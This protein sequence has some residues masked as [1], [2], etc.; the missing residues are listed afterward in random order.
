MKPVYKGLDLSKK[1]K[2]P[3]REHPFWADKPVISTKDASHITEVKQMNAPTLEELRPNPYDLPEGY[4]WF[5]IDIRLIKSDNVNAKSD[6]DIKFDVNIEM[7]YKFLYE[8]YVTYNVGGLQFQLEY[9]IDTIL[10]ILSHTEYNPELHLGIRQISSQKIIGFITGTPSIIKLYGNTCKL[11]EINLLCVDPSYRGK[12]LAPILIKEVTRRIEIKSNDKSHNLLYSGAI[13][14]AGIILPNITCSATWHHRPLNPKKLIDINFMPKQK[15]ALKSVIKIHTID[16]KIKSKLG[17]LR[18]VSIVDAPTCCALLN[19]FLSAYHISVE[20]SE[21]EFIQRF[22]PATSVVK[23][24]V[25]ENKGVIT[26]FISFYGLPSKIHGHKHHQV[27]N[28]AY[29]YYMATDRKNPKLEERLKD[30]M[31]IALCL[32]QEMKFD[33]FNCLNIMENESFMKDLK[34]GVGDGTLQYHLYNWQCPST[35]PAGIGFFM[36]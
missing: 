33:V 13:Y 11:A 35:K 9:S 18:I 16:S 5:N 17:K 29:G 32:A 8:H 4:Q 30:L 23:A 36:I 19:E 2:D 6:V 28:T 1:I 20:F 15:L 22:G 24:Y 21:I 14:T 25:I 7:I 31:H 3:K 10:W 34:F 27:L 12:S 26:D